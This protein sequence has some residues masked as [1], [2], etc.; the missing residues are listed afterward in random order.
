[1]ITYLPPPLKAPA[2]GPWPWLDA[3][4]EVTVYTD[5]VHL[6]AR[7]LPALHAFA[8]AIGLKRCWY[9]GVRK[10]HPHYD[11]TTLQRRIEAY[12]LGARMV[13]ARWIV[14]EFQAGRM[15]TPTKN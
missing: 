6:V 7:T 5:G 8:A 3:D 10:G 14:A 12:A 11:M 2:P 15:C 9:H 13:S 1:M 4:G